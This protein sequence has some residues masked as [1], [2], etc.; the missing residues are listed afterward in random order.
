LTRH[1]NNVALIN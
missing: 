1:K